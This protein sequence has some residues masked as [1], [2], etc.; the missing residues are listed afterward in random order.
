M[1]SIRANQELAL[2][3]TE[4]STAIMDFVAKANA[5]IDSDIMPANPGQ[6]E[7]IIKKFEILEIEQGRVVKLRIRAYPG[8][9]EKM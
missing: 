6:L 1:Q 9:L 7:N 8:K 5:L 4:K 3:L 2:K